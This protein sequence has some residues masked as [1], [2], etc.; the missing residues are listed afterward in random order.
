MAKELRAEL[1]ARNLIFNGNRAQLHKRLVDH[2]KRNELIA[3]TGTFDSVNDPRGI[4]ERN[5]IHATYKSNLDVLCSKKLAIIRDFRARLE[6]EEAGLEAGKKK[7]ANDKSEEL[8]KASERVRR[9]HVAKREYGDRFGG[10]QNTSAHQQIGLAGD[11]FGDHVLDDTESGY[12]QEDASSSSDDGKSHQGSHRVMELYTEI[13]SCSTSREST[14]TERKHKRRNATQLEPVIAK[15]RRLESLNTTDTIEFRPDAIERA[16]IKPT[17]GNVPHLWLATEHAAIRG[18]FLSRL[19]WY[20][21]KFRA[22]YVRANKTGYFVFF[23]KDAEKDHALS[24]CRHD[25]DCRGWVVGE[26]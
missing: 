19:L 10:G 3:A 4:K 13:A 2:V 1:R 9:S 20:F 12:Y 6:R 24:A 16:F 21:K 22:T 7:L 26:E 25:G 15:K 11:I 14:S 18:D 23:E 17:L 5:H 8:R